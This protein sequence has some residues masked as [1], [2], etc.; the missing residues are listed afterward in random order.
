MVASIHSSIPSS[1]SS[2]S[3]APTF[4]F[5]LQRVLADPKLLNDFEHFL[6]RTWCHE[7][8]LFIE[9][10]AQLRHEE[11][12]RNIEHS[13]HRLV[14]SFHHRTSLYI[15]YILWS[16]HLPFS[17]FF[18]Y[19]LHTQYIQDLHYYWCPDGTQHYDTGASQTENGLLK[20][21]YHH[22]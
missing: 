6:G 17:L 15:P 14:N 20:V 13:L 9:A 19:H 12:Q 7:N 11:N 16:T 8:L 22:S 10:M 18:V 5:L 3:T 4:S 21:V 2:T 1:S